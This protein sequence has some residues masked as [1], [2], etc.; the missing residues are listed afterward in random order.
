M[1][2]HAFKVSTHNTLLNS[3]ISKYVNICH[4]KVSTYSTYITSS[5]TISTYHQNMTSKWIKSW[6]PKYRHIPDIKNN[7]QKTSILLLRGIRRFCLRRHFDFR[8]L[9][10]D[11]RKTMKLPLQKDITKCSK[12][13]TI[14]DIIISW[15]IMT[16]SRY[17]QYRDITISWYHE[18]MKYHDFMTSRYWWN[19][20]IPWFQDSRRCEISYYDIQNTSNIT[21]YYNIQ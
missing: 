3:M 21:Q 7:A 20:G 1:Q 18:I 2:K 17:H 6:H 9:I 4:S 10:L 13:D 5:E 14:L 11:I 8:P 15:H 16:S 12:M 19:H